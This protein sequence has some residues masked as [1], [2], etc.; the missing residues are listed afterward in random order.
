VILH[1]AFDANALGWV[2]KRLGAAA[3]VVLLALDA[4]VGELVADGQVKGAV[5]RNTAL[6]AIASTIGIGRH[7]LAVR[8]RGV[9]VA[10]E[11]H[12]TIGASAI[13]GAT[14]CC[15][16]QNKGRQRGQNMQVQRLHGYDL[17]EQITGTDST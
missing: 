5:L 1:D 13:T 9:R 15:D 14:G 11:I 6:S 4:G 8:Q 16:N 12:T 3:V 17:P 10:I 7:C 2:A